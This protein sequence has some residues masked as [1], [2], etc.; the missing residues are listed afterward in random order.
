MVHKPS[1]RPKVVQKIFRTS[2][3]LFFFLN[4]GM[5][6]Y[7]KPIPTLLKKNSSD[8]TNLTSRIVINYNS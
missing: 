4:F 5:L 1:D 7:D 3:T 6:P 2:L 8:T